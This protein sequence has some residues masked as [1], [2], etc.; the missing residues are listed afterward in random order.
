MNFNSLSTQTM[1]SHS[2]EWL[3]T[4]EIRAMLIGRP[5]TLALIVE[6]QGSHDELAEKQSQR[7]RIFAELG[8]ITGEM[9]RLDR[10]HDRKAR[11]M[12]ALL[13]GLAEG[14]EDA[15][16]AAQFLD[17]LA[18]LFPRGLGVVQRSYIDEAGAVIEMQRQVTDE[19]L[20]FMES[21]R[22]DA[23]SLADIY[24]DWVAV[25]L[26]LGRL[27]RQRARLQRA[28][29]RNGTASATID[30]RAAR[31]RWIRTVAT[32]V[33]M[34]AMLKLSDEE[35]EKLLA[36]LERSIADATRRRGNPGP[37]DDAGDELDG[38]AAA[39][40]DALDDAGIAALAA[41][42]GDVDEMFEDMPEAMPGAMAGEM[43]AGEAGDAL[44]SEH[45]APAPAAGVVL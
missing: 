41:L 11:A 3:N 40:L 35:R 7:A 1:L 23:Q 34:V 31:Q 28:I 4:P 37:D 43:I 17:L 26:A 42:P 21:V 25:G 44:G 30:T 6:L 5:L 13:Q 29:T 8:Q 12:H 15:G 36:P 24:R 22:V 19:V 39:G 38:D 20:A 2:D 45:G 33:S 10:I 32:L 27:A 14:T 16:K 18:R 9:T